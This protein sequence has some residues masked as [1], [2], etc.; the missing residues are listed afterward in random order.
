MQAIKKPF[1]NI[2]FAVVLLVKSSHIGQAQSQCAGVLSKAL[3][4]EVKGREAVDI[5]N[6]SQSSRT[7]LG[8]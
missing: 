7:V 1:I 3:D 2:N 8:P 4:T 6:L 5:F